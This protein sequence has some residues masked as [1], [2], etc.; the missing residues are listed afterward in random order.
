MS[1]ASTE[2]GIALYESGRYGDALAL[3]ETL[4]EESSAPGEACYWAGLAARQLARHDDAIDHLYLA[5]HYLAGELRVW[6][7]LAGTLK[8]VARPEE[9]LEAYRE[10]E[11]LTAD[12][13]EVQAGIAR[14]LKGVGKLAEAL[15]HFARAVE[16][17]P[18]SAV[19]RAMWALALLRDG[20]IEQAAR[21]C[22]EACERDPR[23]VEAWH[24]AGLIER[25]LGKMTQAR[26]RFEHALTLRPEALEIRSAYANTLRDLGCF[27]E[28][29]AQYDR[30]LARDPGLNEAQLNRAYL[31]LMTGRYADGWDEYEQRLGFGSVP[32]PPVTLPRWRGESGARVLVYGE[33]GLGDEIMFASCLPDLIARSERVSFA[34]HARLVALFRR[35]FPSVDIHSARD[36]AQAARG[37]Q[38]IAAIGSLPAVFRRSRDAFPDGPRAYLSAAPDAVA[39]WQ[40]RFGGAQGELRVGIS[41]RGGSRQTRGHLR[42]IAPLALAVLGVVR[43]I[44]WI[45]LQYGDAQADYRELSAAGLRIERFAEIESDIDACAAAIGALDLVISIDNTVAHLAAALGRPLW[46]ALAAGP[47][48]RYGIEGGS[49]PWYPGA[50]LFRQREGEGWQAV[51]G[52]IRRALEAKAHE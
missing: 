9:A 20:Q 6:K 4:I 51:L 46:I 16:L 52:E 30:V 7:A 36:A 1:G 38:C 49:L 22:A 43:P 37:A 3:F 40:A 14:I 8:L 17:D 15:P 2:R 50:R 26:Q 32:P 34:C 19:H 27:G 25:E 29:L 23:C 18:A 13:A 45:S 44:R 21:V 48:W 35:S 28:A 47:E 5:S 10:A 31:K 24:H 33:Q 12:D 42:S 11:R 39:A 41:W